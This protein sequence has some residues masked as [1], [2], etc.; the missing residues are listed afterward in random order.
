MTDKE[1]RTLVMRVLMTCGGTGGHINP[2]IAIANTIKENIPDAEILFV[3]TK[4]GKESELVPRAG[5]RLEFV[6]SEGIRRS[7][8]PANIRALYRALVSPYAARP[9][10]RDFAPDLVVG[11]GGYACWPVLKGASMLGIP[12][13][14]H[15]SNAIP[16]MAVKR[17][18]K[19]VDKILINFDK[20]RE[21]IV[22][23]D[24]IVRVGN[25]LSSGF[26]TMEKDAAREKHGIP[27]DGLC[28]LS[29]GGSGGAEF[30]NSIAVD[31]M[32]AYISSHPDIT[33]I[34]AAGARDYPATRAR[35]EEMGLGNCENI[36]LM[37]YIYD[38]PEYMAA[39]DVVIC[40]AGAMTI[41]ELSMMKKACVMIPSPNVVD[42]HQYKN[43][44]VL[45][46]AGAACLLE[47]DGLDAETLWSHLEGLLYD[48]RKRRAQE[49]AISAFADRDA[50]QHIFE[51]LMKIARR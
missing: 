45:S 19:S 17:L 25:P 31:V 6:E 21:Y 49:D 41:S 48:G 9:L 36:R 28:V 8:S 33:F 29:Y 20:T 4:R 26:S 35:F 44:K 27:Q 43:A 37:E 11:T 30:L 39:A 24:K 3:G 42:N 1:E 22:K 32:K 18:Q 46:D 10:I 23:K 2:A 50:N 7:L 15:E 40:R 38:M 12:C 51:E 14:V 16:G 34:H 13:A 47:E 5:Y